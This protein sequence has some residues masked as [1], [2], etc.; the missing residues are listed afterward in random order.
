MKEYI[1]KL[2]NINIREIVKK[3]KTKQIGSLYTSMVLGIIIGIIV[4]V[5]NTRLL[6][7]KQYGDLKFLENLFS[8]VVTFLTLGV[9][10]SGSRL[11][12]LE[13]NEAIKHQ[14][15]GNLLILSSAVSVALIIGLF[16][17]S[18]FEER[19]FHNELGRIIRI[20]SP[21][22]FVFP[23][24]LCL[25]SIMQ[26]DN[27][28]YELSAFQIGPRILYIIGAISF[29]YFVHLSLTSALGI[30]LIALATIILVMIIRLQPKFINIKKNLSIIWQENKTYGF[31]VYIG[32]IAGVASGQLG[33]LSIGYFI[34]NT[35]VGFFSLALTIA[36]PLT[37]IPNAVGTTF[38]KDFANRD[39]IPKKATAVTTVLSIC[40]L[41]FFLL[42]IKK[43]ILLLYS[44]EYSAVV[45][46]AYLVS[47]GCIFHGFGDYI[48]RFI[49]AHGKGKQLRN[50][51]FA[52]GVSNILGYIILVYFF[53]VKGAAITK[54]ISGFIYWAM[55]YHFY[56]NFKKE[57]VVKL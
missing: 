4:S 11:L 39:S 47:V 31:Q 36:M 27:R 2:K 38:F 46:L 7:P 53:G 16:V 18:F 48:N 3:K 40:A 22:L 33:G 56:K 44:S 26:G 19:I 50:G 54:I 34:D 49:G 23:F 43:V 51:A 14:L 57:L 37:M 41:I 17:F 35:N 12:A 55:M 9:F 13:K 1:D 45:P 5:I 30:Q 29:N 21:L 32:T 15:I 52:V 42:I 28:I 20:F 10:V 6:G 25:Q 24:Q 8:F